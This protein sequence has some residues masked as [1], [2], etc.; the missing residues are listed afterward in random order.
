MKSSRQKKLQK[1]KKI[2]LARSFS[3]FN[4]EPS[5]GFLHHICTCVLLLLMLIRGSIESI[6]FQQRHCYVCVQALLK[7][8]KSKN[9]KEIQTDTD[10]YIQLYCQ[11][12]YILCNIR[13]TEYCKI[14]CTASDKWH[15]MCHCM[16]SVS[17]TERFC[18]Y[19][20]L[21]QF[22]HQSSS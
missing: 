7:Q 8:P 15:C 9:I 6:R 11:V 16:Y 2:H 17:N 22:T 21:T 1:N 20:N 14:A 19:F 18:I 5:I 12:Y 4:P 10:F 13:N 3:S